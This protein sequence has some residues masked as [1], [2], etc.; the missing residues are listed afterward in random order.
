[1]MMM[2]L[3]LLRAREL[4]MMA[5]LEPSWSTRGW[6]RMRLST[7]PTKE[8]VKIHAVFGCHVGGIG[9]IVWIL[10]VV[11]L[12]LILTIWVA[13]VGRCRENREL[14]ERVRMD[15]SLGARRTRLVSELRELV[16]VLTRD[17]RVIIFRQ[18]WMRL[19]LLGLLVM[20][21]GDGLGRKR[22]GWRMGADQRPR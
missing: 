21:R 17:P 18:L 19:V 2:M 16:R 1:M 13:T 5:A 4:M 8:V 14:M 10:I 11:I 15:N 22:A 20:G 7:H 9:A 12:V 3:L 6:A